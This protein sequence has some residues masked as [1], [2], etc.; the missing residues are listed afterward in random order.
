MCA[1]NELSRWLLDLP[2]VVVVEKRA[3]VRPAAKLAL[4]ALLDAHVTLFC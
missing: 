4:H 3:S 2:A 1:S